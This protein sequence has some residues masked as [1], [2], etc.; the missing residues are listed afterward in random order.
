MIQKD[1]YCVQYHTN[2]NECLHSVF[3]TRFAIGG[4]NYVTLRQTDRQ[5]KLAC[6]SFSTSSSGT[7]AQLLMQLGFSNTSHIVRQ[8]MHLGEMEVK[9]KDRQRIQ[10]NSK[11]GKT[12]RKKRKEKR[13]V[14]KKSKSSYH[15]E[16]EITGEGGNK[17]VKDKQGGGSQ[18]KKRKSHE[19][20]VSVDKDNKKRK[21]RCGNCGS[22]DGH[23]K[24]TCPAITRTQNEKINTQKNE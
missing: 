8:L 16:V 20:C 5:F 24:R 18:T 3:H 11:E 13:K 22:T 4:K 19:S 2:G 12:S 17:P 7:Q 10:R 6:C 9:E 14:Q 23:N 15:T 21:Y 1:L